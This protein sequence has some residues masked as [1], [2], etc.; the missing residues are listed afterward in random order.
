MSTATE[1]HLSA[2]LLE[3]ATEI[4]MGGIARALSD[5]GTEGFNP[6]DLVLLSESGQAL[7]AVG[8]F[9]EDSP[10]RDSMW[11]GHDRARLDNHDAALL[12]RLAERHRDIYAG[13][14]EL[15]MLGSGDACRAQ[16]A[17]AGRV[18]AALS[19]EVGAG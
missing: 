15:E 2:A 3:D 7:V 12:W 17:R 11:P 6:D 16:V 18:L 1:V 13:W 14:A 5:L 4:A 10:V 8:D 9:A 19:G